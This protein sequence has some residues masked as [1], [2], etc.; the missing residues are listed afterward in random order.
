M[1][2]LHVALCGQILCDGLP[3][4]GVVL[5]HARAQDIVLRVV[6]SERDRYVVISREMIEPTNG[7][8]C[9]IRKS[10]RRNREDV[11]VRKER[12]GIA[13]VGG[14]SRTDEV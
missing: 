4:L 8:G 12:G 9:S 14:V 7:V 1:Q 10:T 3:V 11:D 2:A 6:N 5:L 13:G